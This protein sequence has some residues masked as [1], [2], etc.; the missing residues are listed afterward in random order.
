MIL[1]YHSYDLPDDVFTE[2]EVK[3]ARPVKKKT[4]GVAK[5]RSAPDVCI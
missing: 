2:G 5:K 1:T 3:P 4:N